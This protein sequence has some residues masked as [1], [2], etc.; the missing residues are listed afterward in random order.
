MVR[1]SSALRSLQT[2]QQYKKDHDSHVVV[3]VFR[4]KYIYD[5]TGIKLKK[6]VG[7]SVTL[8]AG[9]YVY[10]GSEGNEQLQF[11]NHSEGYTTPDGSGGYDYVYQY[12]DHLGNVRLSYTDNNGTLEIIEENNYYP[13]GL[14]HK[15]YN[16]VVS[17]LGNSVA[18]RWKFGGKE[19]QDE[20]NLAWY[21][22]SARNYDP[23][24]G[25][26]MNI[27]PLALK[28]QSISPYSYAF[29]TPIAFVDEEGMIP[30]SVQED[31]CGG[32]M[33]ANP[34]ISN[35]PKDAEE[36][37]EYLKGTSQVGVNVARYLTPAE[38]IYGLITGEDFD[39]NQ[40]NRAEAGAW[41]V[42]GTIPGAK[43]GKLS[44][45][46]KLGKT[47]KFSKI[48]DLSKLEGEGSEALKKIADKINNIGGDHLKESDLTGAILD[49][50]G[51][52]VT[53]GGRTF[54][55]MDEVT[56]ALR[57]LRNQLVKLNKLIDSGDLGEDVL[58]AARSL[59]SQVQNQKD[60]IQNVL[61]KAKRELNEYY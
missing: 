24:L 6:T 11:F 35:L 61:N 2:S 44:S 53:K 57:G 47:K 5:A 50:S 26:W 23:A 60:Q 46:L 31:C 18:Q 9:N 16:E 29:N 12:K 27:D 17:P 25:R 10:T 3:F 34:I 37:K 22:V 15:G 20:L 55:H 32:M 13:F 41:A 45:L 38:D 36:R 43:I 59:R 51:T 39:G 8:Y 4:F 40:Y 33:G 56:S 30:V 49:I 42:V 28:M 1:S 14:K 48:G 54:D 52:P 19:Y 21:D 7:S 58:K